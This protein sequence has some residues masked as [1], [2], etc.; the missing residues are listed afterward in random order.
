M[1]HIIGHLTCCIDYALQEEVQPFFI[2]VF[3]ENEADHCSRL[4]NTWEWLTRLLPPL[5]KI[6]CLPIFMKKNE[7]REGLHVAT[8]TK[9]EFAHKIQSMIA[10]AEMGVSE[11]ED[12]AD[13]TSAGS[14]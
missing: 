6:R 9:S 5:L 11:R 8:I 7:Q 12:E 3:L 13:R 14:A 1:N 2:L 4:Q 10:S